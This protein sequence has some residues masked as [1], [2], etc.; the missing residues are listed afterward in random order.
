MQSI[1]LSLLEDE[2]IIHYIFEYSP[3]FILNPR[4]T[5]L[6]TP[7]LSSHLSFQLHQSKVNII[8]LN[9]LALHLFYPTQDIFDFAIQINLHIFYLSGKIYI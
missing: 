5:H 9:F 8:F 2:D 4:F 6:S 3:P 1:L 7:T